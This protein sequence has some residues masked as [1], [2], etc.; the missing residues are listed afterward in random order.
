MMRAGYARGAHRRRA[1]SVP[2]KAGTHRS[3][4]PAARSSGDRRIVRCLSRTRFSLPWLMATRSAGV[5]AERGR[6][7]LSAQG[8]RGARLLERGYQRGVPFGRWCRGAEA[9]TRDDPTRGQGRPLGR[10]ARGR[11]PLPSRA[12]PAPPGRAA[13]YRACGLLATVITFRFFLSFTKCPT[14]SAGSH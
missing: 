9:L 8:S 12:G 2:A 5:R 6:P 10:G 4:A 14:F 13:H 3:A 7:P 11:K 1:P